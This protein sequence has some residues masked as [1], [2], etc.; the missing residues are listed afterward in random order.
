MPKMGRTHQFLQNNESH[1]FWVTKAH[2]Y[3]RDLVESI[4][5][6]RINLLILIYLCQIPS[7]QFHYFQ[8]FEYPKMNLN[9][10]SSNL[11]AQRKS[12]PKFTHK[13][14]INFTRCIY[15][16]EH[17]IQANIHKYAKFLKYITRLHTTVFFLSRIHIFPKIHK[18]N[19]VNGLQS[20]KIF[21]P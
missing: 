6:L 9:H 12:K 20:S 15:I 4:S 8:Q 19:T 1:R 21:M 18:K 14:Q 10:N 11:H 3:E 7:F 2:I 5:T 13:N 17:P 16:H